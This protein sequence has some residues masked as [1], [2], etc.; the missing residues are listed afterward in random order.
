MGEGT[1]HSLTEIRAPHPHPPKIYLIHFLCLFLRKI[2]FT[3]LC[4]VPSI[5]PRKPD[6]SGCRKRRW[7]KG[8]RSF[9]FVFGH[10]SVTFS[11]ASATS[12]VTFLPDSF[13]RTPFAGLLLRQD[14]QKT[15]KFCKFSGVGGGG[16]ELAVFC[17]LL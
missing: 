1:S 8:V 9:F 4:F 2:V 7:A 15:A 13:C 17:I 11:D 6:K 12:F 5:L 16:P 14:E 3:K 10:F